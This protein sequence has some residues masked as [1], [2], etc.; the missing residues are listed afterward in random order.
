MKNIYLYTLLTGILGFG[1]I[2]CETDKDPVLSVKANAEL[3]AM[4]QSDYVLSASNASDP[5]VIKWKQVDFGF[6]PVNTYTVVLKNKANGQI[7]TLGTATG[8][9]LALTNADINTYAGKVY[10][11][12]GQATDMS[13]SLSYSAYNGELDDAATNEIEFKI[14]PYNP[15]AVEWNYVYAVEGYP[16][17]DFNTAYL[18][19]DI[20]ADGVYEGY[21]NFTGAAA[22]RADGISYTILDGRTL[23]VLANGNEDAGAGFYQVMY[24]QGVAALS[25]GPITWGIVGDATPGGWDTDTEF[26]YDAETRLWTK[27]A[28]LLVDKS[29]K[30][31]GNND[32]GV[33][34]GAIQGHEEDMGGGLVANGENMKVVFEKDTTFLITLNLTEAGKY[35]YTMKATEFEQSSEF[36]T[37]PGNYQ[38]DGGWKPEKDDCF[39]LTSSARDFIYSGAYYIPAG[40]IFK[41]YDKG[42]WTGINGNITWNSDYTGGSF[43]ISPGGGDNIQIDHAGY[44]KFIVD[45]KKAT[46]TFVQTGWGLIGA[47]SPSGNW[48]N[49][50]MMTYDPDKNVWTVTATLVGGE[51]KFRWD[52]S[53]DK[54][55]GG[56]LSALVEGGDNIVV[57]AGNYTI[58]LNEATKT[59]TM[60][61]N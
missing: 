12:P 15:N 35:T 60:T 43:A 20:D 45:Y 33:N 21:V 6:T 54:N 61:P 5:F 50:T 11:Y 58:V 29:F 26:E 34:L 16:D 41:F 59:A 32:W 31:R 42:T 10:A 14:T 36:I 40:T 2:S 1:L 47:G 39:K 23:E 7:I 22:T 18:L 52:K 56:S 51:M 8:G 24:S 4:P 37:M 48:D 13:V 53:W 46:A 44:F 49:D 55:L 3:E 19:G 28:R 57:P 25:G 9:E 17:W 38:G 27:V 30:F